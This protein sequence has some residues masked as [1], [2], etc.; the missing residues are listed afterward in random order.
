MLLF[1][2]LKPIHMRLAAFSEKK[3]PVASAIRAAVIIDRIDLF[4]STPFKIEDR[5]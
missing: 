4:N 1:R 2:F 5:D 3:F